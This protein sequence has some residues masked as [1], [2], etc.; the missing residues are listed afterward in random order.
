MGDRGSLC[1]VRGWVWER[2]REGGVE[3]GMSRLEGGRGGSEISAASGGLFWVGGCC[4]MEKVC[5]ACVV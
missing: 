4:V 2:E 5:K 3:E 1:W